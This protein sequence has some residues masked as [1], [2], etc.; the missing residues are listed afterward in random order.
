MGCEAATWQGVQVW[1]G[2]GTASQIKNPDGSYNQGKISITEGG[3]ISR[4]QTAIELYGPSINSAGGQIYANDFSIENCK[5][6]I[7]YAAYR[8]TLPFGSPGRPF[9]YYGDLRS[10]QFSVN[11]DYPFEENFDAFIRMTSVS[12]LEFYGCTFTHTAPVEG[13][14]K[15]DYGY[16]ISAVDAE[17]DVLPITGGSSP[18]ATV[19]EFF[20]LGYG[21][22][23]QTAA[24]EN[25]Q[26]FQVRQ[27]RFNDCYVGV[28]NR[29]VTSSTIVLNDFIMGSLP[30]PGISDQQC[31][32]DLQYDIPSFTVEENTFLNIYD[33]T[34]LVTIGINC[35]NT[36][37]SNFTPEHRFI[38]I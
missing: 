23:A 8:N 28:F 14:T 38:L 18:F 17:F 27:A 16:G 4:A 21:V 3:K 9:P 7:V 12:G 11:E 1:G 20:G 32:I 24:F 36:G 35:E 31:G 25:A 15:S 37:E 33:G 13:E 6:G 22:Y 19:S 29:S 34:D 2:A 5:T 26:P 30:D 10:G